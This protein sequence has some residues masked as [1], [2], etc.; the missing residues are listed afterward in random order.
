MDDFIH[1]DLIEGDSDKLDSLL[2]KQDFDPIAF[3]NHVFPTEE[4]L[5]KLDEEITNLSQRRKIINKSIRQSVRSYGVLGDRSEQILV[6][7][8]DTI[9]TLTKKIT[10]IQDQATRTETVVSDLCVSIK[11]LHNARINLQDSIKAIEQFKMIKNSMDQLERSIIEKNFSECTRNLDALSDLLQ[12]YDQYK[13]TPQL[14]PLY[15]KYNQQKNR[16]R[17]LLTISYKEIISRGS[18]DESFQV[19]CNCIDAFHDDFHDIAVNLF[20]SRLLETYD[21]AFSWNPNKPELKYDS[22]FIWFKNRVEFFNSKF[23]TQKST[24]VSGP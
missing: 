3:I 10:S 15:I 17:D 8:I 2:A 11:P 23:Q 9:Q 14:K 13:E 4:S 1:N 22:R 18:A 20:C 12:I 21:T 6:N 16:L 5:S 19:I 24:L 7:T